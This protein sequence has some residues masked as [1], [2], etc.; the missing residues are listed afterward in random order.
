MAKIKI[1]D[2]EYARL[3]VKVLS[4]RNLVEAYRKE[5]RKL[6]IRLEKRR[7]VKMYAPR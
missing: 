4:L 3:H 6:V 1:D 5:M 2:R 7:K